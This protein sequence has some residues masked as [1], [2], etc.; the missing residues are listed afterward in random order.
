MLVSRNPLLCGCLVLVLLTGC[1]NTVPVSTATVT[2]PPSMTPSPKPT[3]TPSITPSPT[4]TSTPLPPTPEGA[5]GF[6]DKRQLSTKIEN[7]TTYYYI[8]ETDGWATALNQKSIWLVNSENY[9]NDV[10]SALPA[11]YKSMSI[12]YYRMPGSP[13]TF[14]SV[15]E[16]SEY[17]SG[18]FGGKF[19]LEP[20]MWHSPQERVSMLLAERLNNKE[21]KDLTAQM[22]RDVLG[23]IADHSLSLALD[24]PV[25]AKDNSQVTT[26]Y[27]DPNK[28]I[29][30]IQIPWESTSNDPSFFGRLAYSYRWKLDVRGGEDE[31]NPGNLVVMYATSYTYR[32]HDWEEADVHLLG[33][34]FVALISQQEPLADYV[35]ARGDDMNNFFGEWALIHK[36]KGV[37]YDE[38]E[39]TVHLFEMTDFAHSASISAYFSAPF[40]EYQCIHF[41]KDGTQ[42]VIYCYA[43]AEYLIK[44]NKQ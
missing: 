15:E 42:T 28:N 7:G 26:K 30:F 38:I 24:V 4:I 6:N 41:E 14:Y 9:P 2:I 35:S 44:I 17:N 34:I 10:A 19:S 13:Q 3:Y 23:E 8:P 1:A 21:E 37:S 18:S 43:P 12:Y 11:G 27:W 16:P 22:L 25:V 33:P 20:H 5:Q 40:L 31:T 36:T 39:A 29:D 32:L